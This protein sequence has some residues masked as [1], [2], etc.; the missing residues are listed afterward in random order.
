MSYPTQ[1]SVE[2]DSKEQGWAQT[3]RHPVEVMITCINI[4]DAAKCS[5]TQVG[6]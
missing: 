2:W 6:Y 3:L 5:L 1:K 4:L